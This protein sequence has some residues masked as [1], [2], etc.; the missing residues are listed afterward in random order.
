MEDRIIEIVLGKESNE[1]TWRSMIYELVKN[2]QLD[3]WD[4]DI[5]ILS[6]RYVQMLKKLKELD[7]RVS[8]KMVLAAAILLKM[9]STLLVGEDMAELDRLMAP[10]DED[11]VRYFYMQS[12]SLVDFMI[13]R[14]GAQ[15]FTVFC[16]GL[17]DGKTLDAALKSAYPN[18]IGDLKELEEKWKNRR[19]K[20]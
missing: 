7:F 10:Q 19:R 6:K 14:H 20:K 4:V 18:S 16:R 17:K 11:A 12:V 3:P 13:R 5:S 15:S 9:K 8:G 1:I 2:E